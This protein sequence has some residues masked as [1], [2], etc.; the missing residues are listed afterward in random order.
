MKR[1]LLILFAVFCFSASVGAQTNI[2]TVPA[3]V[4]E[5]ETS[6]FYRSDYVHKIT[7][8]TRQGEVLA[9][10]GI[11]SGVVLSIHSSVD[12]IKKR[13]SGGTP[14]LFEGNI[15]IRTKPRNQMVQGP[16]YEQMMKAPLR[17]DVQDTVVELEIKQ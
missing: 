6:T 1:M 8:I 5:Y 3:S 15:S 14:I 16:A 17:L 2:K 9:S 12:S 13:D 11:P 10:L 7:F 4:E